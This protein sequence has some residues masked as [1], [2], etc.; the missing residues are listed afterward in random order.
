MTMHQ[1]V[2]YDPKSELPKYSSPIPEELVR[3]LVQFGAD[4]PYG[5][6]SYK[7]D[8][9]LISDIFGSMGERPPR[10]L[11]YFV[12]PYMSNT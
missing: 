4:D 10:G 3:K 12:E 1:I 5:Y 11:E 9:G 8:F 7:L 6:D 2:G